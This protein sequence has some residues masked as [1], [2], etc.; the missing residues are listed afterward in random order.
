MLNLG[1]LY[2]LAE[3]A[4]KVVAH[5]YKAECSFRGSEIFAVELIITEI[6]FDFLDFVSA[7]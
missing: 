5:Q 6:I 7:T 2:C 3:Q 4:H 1:T